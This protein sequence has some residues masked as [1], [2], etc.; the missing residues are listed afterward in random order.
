MPALPAGLPSVQDTQPSCTSLCHRAQQSSLRRALRHAASSLAIFI[1]SSSD[2][3]MCA[4]WGGAGGMPGYASV[5]RPGASI[6][7]PLPL[8]L[9]PLSLLLPSP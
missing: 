2:H 3:G 8:P 7:F 6:L 4:A 5:M 1:D 9:P